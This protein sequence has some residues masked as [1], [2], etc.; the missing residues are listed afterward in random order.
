MVRTSFVL[1]LVALALA[2]CDHFIERSRFNSVDGQL[3][4]AKRAELADRD[5]VRMPAYVARQ[6]SGIVADFE[7]AGLPD[8]RGF[9]ANALPSG[10]P[11]GQL[12]NLD[13]LHAFA[14]EDP[15]VLARSLPGL[16]AP[17]AESRVVQA[18]L[19]TATLA[20][21]AGLEGEAGLQALEAGEEA[22]G[23]SSLRFRDFV[24]FWQ[25]VSEGG[26]DDV[27]SVVLFGGPAPARPGALPLIRP[28][29]EASEG[30]P[31]RNPFQYYFVS[32]Y[33]GEFVDLMGNAI[34]KPALKDG[35]ESGTIATAVQVLMEYLADAER[36]DPVLADRVED[37]GTFY[38]NDDKPTAL[39]AFADF[40]VEAILELEKENAS[41]G[42]AS[43]S[44]EAAAKPE[45]DGVTL[46]EAKFIE[47]GSNLIG[48]QGVSLFSGLFEMLSSIHVGFI[49]GGNFSV[50]DNDTVMTIARSV[51]ETTI[52]RGARRGLYCLAARH[53]LDPYLV[54]DF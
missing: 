32:Y 39:A 43:S 38:P 8:A 21:L 19:V 34:E 17:L 6:I 22:A 51:I 18:A 33:A 25:L 12:C 37:P 28:V 24:D 15:A 48:D 13:R 26:A 10:S 35:I 31:G 23:V 53:H 41:A 5:E 47:A 42:A 2:G 11:A 30:E 27:D 46:K 7:Q 36:K 16:S 40:P 4:Y 49:V 54:V 14:R 29:A 45:K 9:A 1:P 52:R 20:P 44:V 3:E 50:G